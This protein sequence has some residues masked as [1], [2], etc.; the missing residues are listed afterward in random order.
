MPAGQEIKVAVL[1]FAKQDFVILRDD[2]AGNGFDLV[3]HDQG[4]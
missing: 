4:G 3:V 1:G 2:G